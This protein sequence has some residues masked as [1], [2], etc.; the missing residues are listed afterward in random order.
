MIIGIKPFRYW[1]REI[2]ASM[3]RHSSSFVLLPIADAFV[4]QR[5]ITTKRSRT[6]TPS[7]GPLFDVQ[8]E[9]N[10]FHSSPLS[11]LSAVVVPEL[12][13]SFPDDYSNQNSSN[14]T[15]VSIPPIV[16][17]D[18]FQSVGDFQLEDM[19]PSF[20]DNL[21]FSASKEE[22][23]VINPFPFPGPSFSYTE[24]GVTAGESSNE[25]KLETPTYSVPDSI[26]KPASASNTIRPNNKYSDDLEDNGLDDAIKRLKDTD[27]DNSIS[28]LTTNKF[29]ETSS[30]TSAASS[31][32]SSN[33]FSESK[34]GTGRRTMATVAKDEEN[35]S[36]PSEEIDLWQPFDLNEPPTTIDQAEIVDQFAPFSNIMED[37]GPVKPLVAPLKLSQNSDDPADTAVPTDTSAVPSIETNGLDD[38]VDSLQGQL[39]S[40]QREIEVM[41]GD[42]AKSVN[43]NSPK[44]V[45]QLLFGRPDMSTNKST[46]EGMA[47]SNILAKLILEY[48]DAKRRLNKV[49]KQQEL[50]NVSDSE[51]APDAEDS[52]SSPSSPPRAMKDPVLLFDT[53]S[54]IFRA[55]YS[56]PP[57]HRGRDGMP[58]GAVMG[59]CSMINK[60]LLTTM[61]RG[62]TPILVHCLDAPGKSFRSDL[63]PDYKA[64]R[65]PIPLDL[66]PQFNLINR[67]VKAYG[68]VQ[69]Q[70]P[71]YEADDVIATLA[72]IG[73]QTEGLDV[74]ILSGDKDLMQLVT[75]DD[76]AEDSG[77]VHMVDPMSSKVWNHD[78]VKEKWGVKA[79][80]LGDVLALAGDA[81]DNVPGVPG[82]GPKIA[83]QLMNDFGTLESLL[84]NTDQIPQPKRREKLETNADS[85]R[86]SRELVELKRELEW[87]KMEAFHPSPTT[88]GANFEA[89]MTATPMLSSTKIS[90]L[91]MQ[92]IQPDRILAFYDDM[93]FHKLKNQLNDR[94]GRAQQQ[95]KDSSG[96]AA[97]AETTPSKLSSGSVSTAK[98]AVASPS[99]P[100]PKRNYWEKTKRGVP[101]PEDFK[102]V[103]F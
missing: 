10:R 98:T 39:K 45:S 21:A 92:P 57:I 77:M 33:V 27:L 12:D 3:S 6:A 58:I 30:T 62:E 22:K 102:D 80:Q 84:D 89:D 2:L 59:F 53:S 55:Y 65:P 81:A 95:L 24:E 17:E 5:V 54:F 11:S 88:G 69:I 8:K 51:K 38:L 18:Y 66:V 94:L 86:I 1:R 42:K 71:G 85:A 28:R 50:R 32:R 67:A 40:T 64:H 70:A 29:T 68:M 99:K 35:E 97:V 103:P 49:L 63:Y 93:G 41:A 90:E 82:I 23:E 60:L 9:R 13:D 96:P 52:S 47:A 75:E 72:T 26:S 37:S 61:L 48:R 34:T 83:A 4:S 87:S 7:K 78:M 73:S 91:R 16:G 36:P 79:S 74:K 56:N 31:T 46:L 14:N 44:Q 101:K 25:K 15:E 76:D 43:L 20:D 19:P 100:K